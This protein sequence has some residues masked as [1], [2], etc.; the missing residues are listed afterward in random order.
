MRVLSVKESPGVK[1]R[2]FKHVSWEMGSIF[3][4]LVL[5]VII[6]FCNTLICRGSYYFFNIKKYLD[7]INIF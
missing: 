3:Y 2:F 6:K 7:I 5:V 1:E 4:V